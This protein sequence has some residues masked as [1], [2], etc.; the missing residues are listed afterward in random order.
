MKVKKSTAGLGSNVGN[1][2]Y[3]IHWQGRGHIRSRNL[4]HA[5]HKYEYGRFGAPWIN[6]KEGEKWRS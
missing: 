5:K 2:K 6:W 4:L 3:G 1:V